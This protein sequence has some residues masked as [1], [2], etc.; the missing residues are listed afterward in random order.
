MPHIT[1]APR[2]PIRTET[3]GVSH[4]TKITMQGIKPPNTVSASLGR[5]LPC[6]SERS[7]GSSGS[8][9]TNSKIPDCWLVERDYRRQLWA[10]TIGRIDTA[11]SWEAT[12]L[13]RKPLVI[14]AVP[15]LTSVDLSVPTSL[16]ILSRLDLSI[17]I[18]GRW[19]PKRHSL[20][21]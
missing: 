7:C 1:K 3:G 11:S 12:T 2:L 16:L 4:A 19:S 9:V 18:S 10:T 6:Q 15:D 20:L 21:L 5:C 17:G 8:K 13:T 14:C